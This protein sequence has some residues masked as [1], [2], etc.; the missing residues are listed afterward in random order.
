MLIQIAII[1]AEILKQFETM[2]EKIFD[3]VKYDNNYRKK[4]F[5]ID[6]NI[7]EMEEVEILLKKH[8]LTKVQFLRNSIKQLKEKE[9]LRDK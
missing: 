8:N 5:N 6:L 7:D 9:K 4:Q 1:I 2:S 3:K